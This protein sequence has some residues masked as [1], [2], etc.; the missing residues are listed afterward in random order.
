MRLLSRPA[1]P[2]LLVPRVLAPRI[3]R[4]WRLKDFVVERPQYLSFPLWVERF[5]C[6]E[7]NQGSVD[8]DRSNFST[9][10]VG[11]LCGEGGLISKHSN[12]VFERSHMQPFLPS[13][14]QFDATMDRMNSQLLDP[15]TDC[16]LSIFC[17]ATPVCTSAAILSRQHWAQ[18]W[19]W[20]QSASSPRKQSE[21]V[22]SPQA[23]NDM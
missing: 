1:L 2:A 22:G 9:D 3:L 8:L 23:T 18:V 14:A 15:R 7:G 16:S 12:A 10:G 21:C 19:R 17:C 11:E 13:S 6:G 4:F 20:R 5:C